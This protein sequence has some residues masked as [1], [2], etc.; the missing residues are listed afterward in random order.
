MT[1]RQLLKE[2]D[3]HMS[4]LARRIGVTRAAV[5]S[6]ANGLTAPTSAKIPAIAKALGA[7][8]GEVLD[9]FAEENNNEKK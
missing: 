3:L 2:K 5:S 7:S 1:F 9:C 6:W 8:V 4:Q